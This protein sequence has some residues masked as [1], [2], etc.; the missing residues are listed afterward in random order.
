MDRHPQHGSRPPVQRVESE[1]QALGYDVRHDIL[2]A[3]DFGV[4]Q[5][6]KRGDPGGDEGRK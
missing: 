6:R 1:F 3:V 2:N 4:P 5:Q